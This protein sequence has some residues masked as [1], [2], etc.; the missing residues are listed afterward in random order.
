MKKF[1][2]SSYAVAV[3]AAG[4]A[5]AADLAVKAPVYKAS[6]AAPVFSWT[7]FYIGVNPGFASSRTKITDAD[8]WWA[9][10]PL[11]EYTNWG[12][13]G[14]GQIGFNYQTGGLV[15]GIEADLDWLG[16]KKTYGFD[17]DCHDQGTPGNT[18]IMPC[19]NI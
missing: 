5:V 11:H 12:F 2:L 4:P 3:L 15:Y 14:G 6:P 16:T 17:Y 1:L 10:S 9:G 13:A 8:G 7:G 19:V 18:G